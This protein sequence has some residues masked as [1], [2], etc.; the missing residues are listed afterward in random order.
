MR[1]IVT[2]ASGML[3]QDVVSLLRASAADEVVALGRGDLDI[4]DL[5]SCRTAMEGADV[6]VKDR[7]SVV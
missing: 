6:V 4:T 1:W 2:G 3:G 5:A 7:K